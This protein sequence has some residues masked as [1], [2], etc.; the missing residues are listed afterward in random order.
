MSEVRKARGVSLPSLWQVLILAVGACAGWLVWSQ[1]GEPARAPES[2]QAQGASLDK[3]QAVERIANRGAEAVPELVEALSGSDANTRRGALLGLGRLGPTAA[4]ALD[5]IRERLTDEDAQVRMY[6]M[7]AFWRI[8]RNPEE[9]AGVASRL[10]ADADAAVREDA[11]SFLESIGPRAIEPVSGVLNGDFAPAKILALR[12]L[13]LWEWDDENPTVPAAVR[14]LEGDPDPAVRSEALATI[15]VCDKPTIAEIRELLSNEFPVVLSN[16]RAAMSRGGRTSIEIGLFAIVE[17]PT[18]AA[19]LLPELLALSSDERRANVRGLPDP[20]PRVLRALGTAAQPAAPQLLEQYETSR[21]SQRAGQPARLDMLAT[22][23]EIGADPEKL[24][25]ILTGLL[26]DG[27]SWQC[28]AVAVLLAHVSPSEARRIASRLI[29][30]LQGE[31]GRPNERAVLTLEGLAAYA[32]EAIPVLIRMIDF[33]DGF[34]AASATRTLGELGPSAAPAVPALVAR[35]QNRSSTALETAGRARMAIAE[36]LGKI[37]PSAGRAVPALIAV[38]SEPKVDRRYTG[39]SAPE[40]QMDP[41]GGPRYREAAIRALSLIGICSPEV[42]SSMQ[43]QLGHESEIV[44]ISAIRALSDLAPDSHDALDEL[45]ERLSDEKPEVR[46]H[47]AL[48]IG[49]MT[50]DLHGAIPALTSAL[51]DENPYVRSAAALTLGKIGPAAKSAVPALQQMLHEPANWVRNSR[52]WPVGER[53]PAT[54]FYIRELVD[55]SIREAARSALAQ[56][57]E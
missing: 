33:P 32:T 46:A 14:L 24:T 27:L 22:L 39:P 44:R 20:F 23:I 40:F 37:G 43:S 30:D 29:A 34:I 57:E 2:P 8:S 16:P 52:N 31:D 7:T 10:L 15:A 12:L 47:A 19:E 13:R 5:Q 51:S 25:R 11:A 3:L 48:A 54:S 17:R 53:Y 9:A 28:P 18:V 35:L 6:A 26:D 1:F 38:S 56:V 21:A 41:T 36:T 42:L 45:V 55:L 50:C 4:E 49:S